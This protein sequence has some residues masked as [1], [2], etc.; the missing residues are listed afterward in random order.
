MLLHIR[1]QLVIECIGYGYRYLSDL[2]NIRSINDCIVSIPKAELLAFSR[3]PYG[4][5]EYLVGQQ[6]FSSTAWATEIRSIG[7]IGTDINASGLP[8][9]MWFFVTL[10]M[11]HPCS[12]FEFL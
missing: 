12:V 11:K 4:T 7:W 3:F 10:A 5:A 2:E 8:A 9:V 6:V 1:S